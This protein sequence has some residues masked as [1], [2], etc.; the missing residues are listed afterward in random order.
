MNSLS[1]TSALIAAAGLAIAPVAAQAGTRAESSPV[2][3]D[4]QRSAAGT[5]DASNVNFANP[6]WILLLLAA[7]AALIAV[8]SGGRSRG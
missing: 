2:T 5:T 3:I 1:K 6:A 4:V 7:I 8:L